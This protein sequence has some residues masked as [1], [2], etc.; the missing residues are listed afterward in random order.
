MVKLR[1]YVYIDS[2]QPQLAEYM[3]SVSQGFPPVPGDS[4]LWVEVSPGMAVH[5]VTDVALKATQVKLTQQVVE[6]AFGSMVVHHRDQSDVSQAGQAL[7]ASVDAKETDREQCKIEWQEIIRGMT[8]DHTVLINRQHRGGSMMLPGESM[9]ILETQPAGYI[10]YAANQAEKAA[11]ITLI[12]VRAVG[13]YGR[14]TLS[15]READVEEA[16]AAAIDAIQHPSWS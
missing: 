10:V 16:A 9:F 4:C 1:T 5:Q 15:G 8:S 3:A 13:A 7:L 2:L 14:L 12:D 11:N 6:R